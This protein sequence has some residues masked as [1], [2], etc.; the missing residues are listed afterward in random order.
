MGPATARRIGA[1]RSLCRATD[2][3]ERQ[4]IIEYRWPVE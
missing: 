1:K 3:P 4:R 2:D